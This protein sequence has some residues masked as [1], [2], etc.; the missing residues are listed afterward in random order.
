MFFPLILFVLGPIPLQ[1]QT[2]PSLFEPT[3]PGQVLP[4]D[5]LPGT[6]ARLAVHPNLDILA[7]DQT[8]RV[9]I[10][11]PGLKVVAELDPPKIVWAGGRTWHG[12]LEGVP[13]SEI[14]LSLLRGSLSGRIMAGERWF[15]LLDRGGIHEVC[16]RDADLLPSCGN[17]P[18][19]AP[20]LPASSSRPASSG[21]STPWIDLM[22]VYTPAAGNTWYGGSSSLESFINLE[23]ASINRGYENSLVD[24]RIRLVHV[25]KLSGYNENGNFNTELRRL[26]RTSDGHIDNVHSLRNQHGADMVAELILGNGSYCGI[27]YLMTNPGSSFAQWAFSVTAVGCLSGN[28]LSHELG[29]N[30]GCAHDRQNASSGA[31]SYSFGYR[32]TTNPV[33]RTVMAYAPGASINYF[34]NPNVTYQGQVMGIPEGQSG[35]AENW[36]T[37]QNTHPIAEDWRDSVAFWYEVINLVAGEDCTLLVN[38]AGSSSS[39]AFLYSL[40]GSGPTWHNTYGGLSLSHPIREIAIVPV[41]SSGQASRQVHVPLWAAGIPVWTQSV[42]ILPLGTR[43]TNAWALTVQ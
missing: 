11:L 32:T 41:N 7:G 24:G 14:T 1:E 21:V 9:G 10:D 29:H 13:G 42:E 19:Q 3:L 31:Y 2:V 34:S 16:E 38:G 17:G 15:T 22:V 39:V 4:T 30:L 6:L 27:A 20:L 26:Q 36:K 23:V 25:E 5:S 18:S 33:W 8:L 37:L 28:T 43:L 12:A 35:S 40:T